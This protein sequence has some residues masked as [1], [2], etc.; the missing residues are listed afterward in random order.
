MDTA[1]IC[2][3]TEGRMTVVGNGDNG[4]GCGRREHAVRR[5]NI[6]EGEERAD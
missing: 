4:G 5:T 6:W 2:A 3:I 1:E